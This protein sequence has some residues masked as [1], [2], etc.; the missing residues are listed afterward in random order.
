MKLKIINYPF[1]PNV[2][3]VCQFCLIDMYFF[4]IRVDSGHSTE[5][6]TP[7]SV[8]TLNKNSVSASSGITEFIKRFPIVLTTVSG[9][10]SAFIPSAN[11]YVRYKKCLANQ[12]HIEIFVLGV[13][14]RE[15]YPNQTV[16]SERR[17]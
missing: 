5:L 12:R 16:R 1:I 11:V 10:M 7:C 9:F 17:N 8:A 13:N 15:R 14:K 6:L 4:H 2:E 3:I